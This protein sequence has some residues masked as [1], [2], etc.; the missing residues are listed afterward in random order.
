MQSFRDIVDLME[1][2]EDEA[3]AFGYH[4]CDVNPFAINEDNY[5]ILFDLFADWW[6]DNRSEMISN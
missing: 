4:V 2:S 6:E 3:W 5:E 1:L